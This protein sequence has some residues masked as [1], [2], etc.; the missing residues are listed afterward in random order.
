MTRT[1]AAEAVGLAGKRTESLGQ[2]EEKKTD[3]PLTAQ[4]QAVSCILECN[5]ALIR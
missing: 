1:T 2:A 4:E 5:G 3:L